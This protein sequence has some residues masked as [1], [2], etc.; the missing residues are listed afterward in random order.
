MDKDAKRRLDSDVMIA[1]TATAVP[2]FWA[3]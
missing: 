3:A 1:A 2:V